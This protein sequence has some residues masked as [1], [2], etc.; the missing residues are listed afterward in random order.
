MRIRIAWV[1][2]NAAKL[3]RGRIFFVASRTI[4]FCRQEV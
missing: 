2:V 4:A 1:L 3:Y